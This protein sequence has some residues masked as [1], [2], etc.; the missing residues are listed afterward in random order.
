MALKPEY[1]FICLG[2]AASTIVIV[3]IAK[4]IIKIAHKK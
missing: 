3:E 4:L 2:L 1:L